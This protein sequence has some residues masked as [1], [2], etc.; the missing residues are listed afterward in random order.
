MTDVN[1][2]KTSELALQVAQDSFD[3]TESDPNSAETSGLPASASR[4]AT[5]VLVTF[6]N[7]TLFIRQELQSLV[8]YW[9]RCSEEG[10]PV[11]DFKAGQQ[12]ILE[13]LMA[14]MGMVDDSKAISIKE[15]LASI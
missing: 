6:N 15:L 14:V 8:D 2:Q 7:L 4:L 1:I 11:G 10:I 3:F 5:E 12:E 9:E 13:K